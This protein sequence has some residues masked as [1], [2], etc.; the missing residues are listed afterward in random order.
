MV[1]VEV[2]VDLPVALGHD[3]PVAHAQAVAGLQL[4]DALEQRLTGQAELEGQ[5]VL[6]ALEIGLDPDCAIDEGALLNGPDGLGLANL[7]HS[8]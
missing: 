1:E 8:R 7:G 3:G 5:V 2:V 4:A 6:E